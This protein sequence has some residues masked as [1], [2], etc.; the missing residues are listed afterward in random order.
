MLKDGPVQKFAR[1]K[2]SQYMTAM[3]GGDEKLCEKLIPKYPLGCRRI[4]PAPGYL[5]ALRAPNVDV[6]T[7][8]VK[9]IVPEG[10]EL[11][12]GEVLKVDAIICA[13]GFDLSFRPRFPL[14]GRNG[15]LQ[16]IWDKELPKSYMS[17]AIAGLP[18]YFSRF[19]SPGL[20]QIP[21][22]TTGV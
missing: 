21:G 19:L 3:L 20:R 6:V 16:D 4:T 18:N 15:N 8:G 5:Q 2:V 12:S 14:I 11:E 13:T 22:P 9:R 17:C 7:Q 10:I 1:E